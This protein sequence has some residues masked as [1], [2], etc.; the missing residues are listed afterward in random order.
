MALV[1]ADRVLETSTTTGTGTLTLAGAAS[2]YASFSV[3]GNGNTTY[4]C[5]YNTADFTWEI[6]V[7]TYTSSG[8]TLSRDTVYAN[9]SGTTSLISFAAGTKN[10]FVTYPAGKGI[11]KD[12]SGNAIALGTPTSVTLT[13]AT[14]LPLT[15]GV[16]GTL[17]VANGGTGTTASTGPSSVVLRDGNGELADKLV[18]ESMPTSFI[19]DKQGV[20]RHIHQGFDSSDIATIKANI[21]GLLQLK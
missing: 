1:L 8:T 19:L 3:V 10:V 6:G 20:I 16:T 17:P 15:T 13:N 9:S 7:G 18:I 11:W 5:I 2:G 21:D 14:G 12:A 4:Y